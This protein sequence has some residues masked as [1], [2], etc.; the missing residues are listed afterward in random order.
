M[1]IEQK[2][3]DILIR[4]ERIEKFVFSEEKEF[5]DIQFKK[6]DF[7]LGE[8]AFMNQYVRNISGHECFAWIVAYLTKGEIDKAV[9]ISQITEVWNR[10][11]GILGKK[12]RSMFATRCKDN[13]W[14][15]NKDRNKNLYILKKKWKEIMKENE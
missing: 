12:Y 3:E 15:D 7:D 8:R 14:V 4:L 1:N 10:G 2:I 5:K 9:N 6:V 13:G 11:Y